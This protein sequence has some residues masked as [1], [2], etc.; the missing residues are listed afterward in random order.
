MKFEEALTQM[1]TGAK[2]TH[3]S[4]DDDTYL[5]SCKAGLPGMAQE[6]YWLSVV[7]MKGDV[8]HPDMIG[9]KA[10]EKPCK[11]GNFPQ[12]NLLII[13]SDEWELWES[14]IG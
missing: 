2:I 3:P 8:Q 13:I 6:E 11:H 12:L 7:K 1:R 4:F 14:E 10:F 9:G 5:M